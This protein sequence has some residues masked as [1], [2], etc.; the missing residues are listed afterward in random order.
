M[1]NIQ[2][3]SRFEAQQTS[4]WQQNGEVASA[5]SF[6]PL[7]QNKKQAIKEIDEADLAI[8]QKIDKEIEAMTYCMYPLK[9]MES[10]IETDDFSL[11]DLY[12]FSKKRIGSISTLEYE[13]QIENLQ[14]LRNGSAENR[15][16]WDRID[17]LL[18]P[19]GEKQ[20]LQVLGLRQAALEMILAGAGDVAEEMVQDAVANGY[21]ATLDKLFQSSFAEQTYQQ[22]LKNGLALVSFD[23]NADDPEYQKLLSQYQKDIFTGTTRDEILQELSAMFTDDIKQKTREWLESDHRWLGIDNENAKNNIDSSVENLLAIIHN[24]HST[25]AERNLTF[26][27]NETQAF[28]ARFGAKQF[29]VDSK[30]V[31]VSVGCLKI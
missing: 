26:I 5:Q 18:S 27:E 22:H 24:A 23:T 3:S 8:R 21:V 6:A 11:G 29:C 16:I 9:S 2:T 12:D 17:K 7:L 1:N 19:N 14:K 4:L 30:F 15:A 25:F 10:D 28:L 31:L 13:G 20:N